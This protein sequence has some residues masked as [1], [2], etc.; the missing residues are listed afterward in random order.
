MKPISKTEAAAR[1]LDIAIDLYF[2]NAD[3]LAVYTLAYA[4]FKVLFDVYPHRRDDGYA[5]QLD[6]LIAAEGWRRMAGTANFLKHADRDPDALLKAH[7]PEL[8]RSVIGLATLL[9]RRISGDFTLKMR[10]FDYWV[11]E[12]AYEELGIEE[13][14]ENVA[15]VEE[16]RRVREAVRAT[17]RDQR[18]AYAQKQY[19]SYLDNYERLKALVDE[20]QAAGLTATE[21][22]DKHLSGYESAGD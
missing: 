11:E 9:Y 4:V 2:A 1:Q 15:R 5:A 20:S 7:D 19:H 13:V 21:A 22:M 10:A 3:S 16:H 18:I 6:E 12:E 17:P 14:D 8:G